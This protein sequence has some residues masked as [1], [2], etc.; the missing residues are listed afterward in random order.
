MPAPTVP[1]LLAP[2]LVDQFYRGGGQ[3]PTFRGVPVLGAAPSEDW[4]GSVT[5]R[6]GELDAG[7]TRLPDGRYLRD[8]VAG[9]PAG[10]LGPAHVAAFGADT[11]L[12]TKLLDPRD[13]LIVHSHP[14]RDFARTHLGTVHGKTEAWIVLS[15]QPGEVYLGFTRT[16]GRDEL[17]ELVQAQRIPDL[18]AAMN[19]IPVVH[20][21]TILVP[22]GLPHAIGAGVFA[23]ELQEPSD[24]S[25]ALEDPGLAAPELGLGWA[26]VLDSVDRTA[27]TG[28]RLAA[29]RGPGLRSASALPDAA[30]PYFRAE[31][32][33][34]A[35]T[36]HIAAGFA[37]A[38]VLTGSARISGANGA[39]VQAGHG[40][41]VLLPNAA[42]PLTLD[43]T[44]ELIVCRPPSPDQ[45]A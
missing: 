16:V 22:A 35:G 13:R 2:N 44:A 5:T 39:G 6:F 24:L 21:D 14:D 26:L 4:I 12:L 40:S 23:L 1:I 34:C 27:L 29:L 25:V 20:G 36:A 18:L 17:A 43:G 19:R 9:D 28:D 30:D 7:L 42:G 32:V 41:A 38:V 31:F 15:E 8:A 45:S 37:I 11:A 10:F 33:E 3:T